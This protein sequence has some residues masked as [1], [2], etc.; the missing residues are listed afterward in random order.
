MRGG[1]A[2]CGRQL[3]R[4]LEFARVEAAQL[5]LAGARTQVL[6][7]MRAPRLRARPKAACAAA[8][9]L[10]A[11]ARDREGFN[12]ARHRAQ[13]LAEART[14]AAALLRAGGTLPA[15]AAAAPDA[16][17]EAQDEANELS[18]KVR[19]ALRLLARTASGE[20]GKRKGNGK[21]AEVSESPKKRR[22]R[23]SKA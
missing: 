12:N 11:L 5:A 6:R 13:A 1:R 10:A 7:A 18:G 16:L 22:K 2:A 3:G 21:P 19:Q 9:A 17:A 20:D 15:L 4:S 23:A 8:D 14:L